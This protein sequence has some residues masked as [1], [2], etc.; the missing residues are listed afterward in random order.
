MLYNVIYKLEVK[1]HKDN[2]LIGYNS[3]LSHLNFN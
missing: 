3:F 2:I 1:K